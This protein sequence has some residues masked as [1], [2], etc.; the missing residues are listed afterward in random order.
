MK[1]QDIIREIIQKV[2]FTDFDGWQ[3]GLTQNPDKS[4]TQWKE[5]GRN[6]SSWAAWA[7]DSVEEAREIESYFVNEKKMKGGTPGEFS[8]YRVLHVFIF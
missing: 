2:G 7:A 3:I 6:V 4:E 8:P 1:K 5:E